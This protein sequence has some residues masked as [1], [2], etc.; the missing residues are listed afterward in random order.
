[1]NIFKQYGIKE[2]ADVTL[3]SITRI[4]TEEFYIPVL[5]LDT[6]KVTTLDKSVDTVTASGGKG[7]GKLLSWNFQKDLKLKFE[8][9]LFSQMSMN[10]FL[11]GRVMAK[12][13]D[14]TSAIAKCNVANKY[15][16]KNYSIK[17]FPSPKLTAAE[18]EIVFRCA[19][20]A[21]YDPRY[22]ESGHIAWKDKPRDNFEEHASK[23]LYDSWGQDEVIDAVV[24]ENRYLLMDKY[25]NRKQVTPKHLDISEFIDWNKDKYESVSIIL[26]LWSSL[27]DEKSEVDNFISKMSN[28][29]KW[30]YSAAGNNWNVTIIYKKKIDDKGNKNDKLKIIKCGLDTQIELTSKGYV[31]NHFYLYLYTSAGATDQEVKDAEMAMQDIFLNRYRS[32]AVNTDVYPIGDEFFFD[33]ILYYLFPHYLEEIIDD[34]CW[35]DLRD[36]FY[37]AMPQ[38]VINEIMRE[39]DEM[40]KLGHFENDLYEAQTI[41]RMEKCVVTDQKGMKIDKLEQWKNIEKMYS[42][43]QESFSVFYDSKTMLPFLAGEKIDDR[44]FAQK[45]V[46]TN[47][48]SL[49]EKELYEVDEIKSYLENTYHTTSYKDIT[50]NRIKDS[51]YYITIIKRDYLTL[52]PGTV[53]YKWSRTIDEDVTEETFIGTDISIDTDTFSGEY[54]IVGET[55]IREQKTGKDQRYQVIFPRA[56]VSASTSIK[57]QASGDPTTFSLDIAALQPIQK[58]KSA[59]ILRQYDVEEDKVE[60]GFRIVP[61]NK[62]H[63]Y[64]PFVEIFEQ[65]IQQNNEIY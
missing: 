46:Q 52:K 25:Y 4:G 54:M 58:N 14:W 20:K 43:T 47:K 56:K 50:I 1:M 36:K 48:T 3:Y 37:K 59:L 24:A 62:H 11:N 38:K 49:N 34:L 42:D 29:K 13:S 22:G 45:C 9:A 33:H 2:I 12:M 63:T 57:L 10:T 19:Q 44:I 28:E 23:Y 40:K 60:G 39:I 21:G 26:D 15:G 41:D 53:Y 30:S 65:D 16:Q 6:L 17:A 27:S 64:T 32:M 51:Y 5:F 55:Y 8:D 61:Q 7:N 31:V 35:C 18:E